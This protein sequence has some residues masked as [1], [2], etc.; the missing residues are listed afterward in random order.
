MHSVANKAREAA[1]YDRSAQVF[2]RGLVLLA[3]ACVVMASIGY[4]VE[5][6]LPIAARAIRMVTNLLPFFD[7]VFGWFQT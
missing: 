4:S 2:F 5:P 3:L 1:L 6:N 7:G